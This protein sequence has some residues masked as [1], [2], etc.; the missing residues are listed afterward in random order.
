M[1]L[2]YFW[3]ET[4]TGQKPPNAL[5]KGN[6]AISFYN[7]IRPMLRI[8]SETVGW[9]Q[10]EGPYRAFITCWNMFKKHIFFVLDL[11]F[12]FKFSAGHKARKQILYSSSLCIAYVHTCPCAQALA[13]KHILPQLTH[14]THYFQCSNQQCLFLSGLV[15][16]TNNY[17][18]VLE[19]WVSLCR[20]FF[21]ACAE[22]FTV[23]CE[24]KLQTLEKF[25]LQEYPESE[26]MGDR[27]L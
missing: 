15:E 13:F 17:Q 22:Y 23:Y 5:T 24:N 4:W 6:L 7:Q 14:S 9:K 10:I 1:F 27:R 2:V 18:W 26:I 21:F 19:T 12:F 3:N 25:E 8:F 16:G 20:N 11:I